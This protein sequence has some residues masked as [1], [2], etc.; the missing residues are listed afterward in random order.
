MKLI[1]LRISNFKCFGPEPVKVSFIDSTTFLIGPNGSGKTAI[2]QAL[3]RMFASNPSLRKIR[4]DD[5][6]VPYDE[7]ESP[8]ERTLFIEADF[9]LPEVANEEDNS[10]TIPPCFNHMRLSEDGGNISIRYRLEATMG[11]D[12]DIEESL[13]YVTG[14]E[15]D[16]SPKKSR[17]S[18]AERNHI[19][20]H[21]LPAKRDPNDHIQANT[22]SLLG[23][24]IRAIDWS[25]EEHQFTSI[26]EDIMSLIS[27]NSAIENANQQLSEEWEHLHK[28]SHFQKAS[29]FFG[30]ESLERLRNNVSIEFTPAHGAST[31]DFSLLSDGQ[32]SLLYLSLVTAFIEISRTAM[33][34]DEDDEQKIDVSKLNPPIFSI[35][36]VE[37]PENSLSPHYLGRINTLLKGIS[38]EED[39][40]SIVTTHS[41]AMLHRVPPDQ[42]RHTRIG[43]DRLASVKEI[44]LPP[45]S[46]MDV[47]KYVREGILLNPEIY[48]SRFVVLGEGPSESIVLPRLFEAAGLPVDENGITIAQLGGRHVNYMWKILTDLG[49]PYVTL[50][51]LDLSRHQG[52]WGRVKYAFNQLNL[53]N[54]EEY[55]GIENIPQWDES[56]PLDENIEEEWDKDC[57]KVLKKERIFFSEPL[58]LDFS[59]ILSYPKAYGIETDT[60]EFPD[61][62]TIKSVLGKSH[63]ETD[64]YDENELEFFDSY[65]KLF[66]LGSKPAAHI[67]ALS[68]LNNQA[69]LDNFPESYRQLI[70][71]VKTQL[72]EVYE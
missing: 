27:Q 43:Q 65:H 2:L 56:S 40:Q 50:L 19:A 22:T 23:R 34:I 14:Q 37:E 30:L 59:M 20:V 64:W 49:I 46:K 21:Y 62:T 3:A 47:Y 51:D 44:R 10:N 48:F 52:G 31:I 33:K 18:R 60:L 39:A 12:G 54:L 69:I 15:A 45:K 67:R 25:E 6:H 16:D 35:I 28:G 8:E 53:V 71:S 9:S 26:S 1:E 66:K 42:I 57:I 72:Q 13:F 61:D 38:S 11:I 5:F 17:V 4:R 58:D 29:L 70:K 36:A 32:M 41:P 55:D 63:A 68:K 7:Q 24:I